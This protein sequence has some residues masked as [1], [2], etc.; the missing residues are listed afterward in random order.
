MI[1]LI[2][3]NDERNMKGVTSPLQYLL[4]VNHGLAKSSGFSP[5]PQRGEGGKD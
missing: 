3:I 5:P 4:E 1:T 2:G